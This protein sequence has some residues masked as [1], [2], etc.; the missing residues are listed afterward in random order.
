[1]DC[2]VYT[3]AEADYWEGKPG[4]GFAYVSDG[5]ENKKQI[6]AGKI[7]P[8]LSC[9]KVVDDNQYFFGAIP[10]TDNQLSVINGFGAMAGQRRAPFVHAY[11]LTQ[12]QSE[13]ALTG[14]AGF[15]G[16]DSKKKFFLESYVGTRR[17]AEEALTKIAEMPEDVKITDFL[18]TNFE[19]LRIPDETLGTLFV[20]IFDILCGERKQIYW[21]QDNFSGLELIKYGKKLLAMLYSVLPV[22]EVFKLGAVITNAEVL[23]IVSNS[24]IMNC[25]LYHSLPEEEKTLFP[26]TNFYILNRMPK[27]TSMAN[28]IIFK[29]GKASNY[30]PDHDEFKFLNTIINSIKCA[31]NRN[32]LHKLYE[33]AETIIVKNNKI[34]PPDLQ[35]M[36]FLGMA[37]N[38]DRAE[39]T[40]RI[41]S[42]KRGEFLYFLKILHEML[43]FGNEELR[44]QAKDQFKL[45][46]DCLFKH[47]YKNVIFNTK[48]KNKTQK[49]II[50]IISEFLNSEDMKGLYS[51]DL[52][53]LIN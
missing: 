39:T 12:K 33:I 49:N 6:L 10:S 32:A 45:V 5:L 41:I 16:G 15:S 44:K 4:F 34:A 1:L 52:I 24:N 14:R 26:G 9:V 23:E 46:L 13:A 29:N 30:N 20:A 28:S 7:V 11:L 40:D 43:I 18:D 51:Q 27:K 53:D 17:A 47:H 37:V 21:I 35:D 31:E 50:K 8:L 38:T 3:R 19:S 22:A 48:E 25:K 2:V 36:E 42:M